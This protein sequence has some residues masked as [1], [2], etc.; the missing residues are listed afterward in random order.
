MWRALADQGQARDVADSISAARGIRVSD[1]EDVQGVEL[2]AH[3]AERL[4]GNAA[5]APHRSAVEELQ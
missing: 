5:P 4:G 2:V 1:W 3:G